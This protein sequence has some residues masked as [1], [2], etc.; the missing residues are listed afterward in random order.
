M[1]EAIAGLAA[2]T[3]KPQVPSPSGE[4][5]PTEPVPRSLP[6]CLRWLW[7]R[8]LFPGASPQTGAVRRLG[9]LW[10]L[11]L[12]AAVL[13]PCLSFYLFEPDEGRYAQIPFEMAMRGEWITP[14]LQGEPY[15]DKPPLFYWLVMLSYSLFGVHDWAARLVPAIALHGTI[16]LVYLFGCRRL[17][18]RRAFWGALTLA[19]LPGFMGMARLLV[20]DGLLTFLVTLAFFSFWEVMQPM[21]AGPA[22]RGWWLLA[23]LG[24]GLGILCKGPVILI[25]TI[26]P[27]W[28][29]AQLTG[30]RPRLSR[31]VLLAF[32]AG[33]LAIPLPWYLTICA[34][35]PHFAQHFL[36]QHNILRFVQP[37]DHLQPVWYYVPIL[38]SCL[39]PAGFLLIPLLRALLTGG[40]EAG[41]GRPPEL[42][43]LL[44][45]GG[46][47]VLFFSLSG[48][49]LPT[50]ILPAFP[51]LALA[52]G[53]YLVQNGWEKSRW[54][55]AAA[56]ATYML[57]VI[58]HFALT[59][60]L[61]ES[62]SPMRNADQVLALGRDRSVPVVCHP[63][64]L[65]SVA[66]Y[67]G[68]DDLH[69]FRGKD[70]RQ[71]IELL[72]Q[73]PRTVV[74]F[75]Q[76]EAQKLLRPLLPPDLTMTDTP[77]EGLCSLAVVEC[78]KKK[79]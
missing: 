59:P 50:Y 57:I 48:S 7:S 36:W 3:G 16:L 21:G 51:P 69:G 11:L 9:L 12:P 38:L 40:P 77:P 44:L 30:L 19:L 1:T 46:W 2:A 25:L 54:I 22:R 35:M 58:N 63:R 56:V 32:A 34:R 62:R 75:S 45:A 8:V 68:R 78:R 49:K 6:A 13:Y 70:I 28:I 64:N 31:R 24:C 74:L 15:L 65:D 33:T 66:F 17:G 14:Y 29:Y 4:N 60:W 72:R 79:W 53:L 47:C 18:E 10:L 61:A 39:L 41:A 43:F 37:F 55:R 20:L 73:H 23:A 27:L 42:G 76:R 52:L 71:M 67:L 5:L 26:P